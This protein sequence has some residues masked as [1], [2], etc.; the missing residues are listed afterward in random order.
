[1]SSPS[2]FIGQQL[3]DRDLIESIVSSF[4]IADYGFIQNVNA[5]KTVDVVHA[6]RLKNLEGKDL[7][8]TITRNV[9]VLTIAG[10]AFSVSVDYQ[11]GDKVLL[12]GLKN[13]IKSVD[14]A[15][16]S[17]EMTV[18]MHYTRG[19]IKALPLC[20]FNNDAKVKA[21]IKDGNFSLA[22]TKFAVT[23]SNG[24]AALEVTP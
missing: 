11:P 21:E 23:D 3:T 10:S 15:D 2:I 7:G 4:Y 1:M 9:E 8:E 22:C 17:T 14:D 24:T 5:D 19:T 6:K 20:V 12:L 18:Y 13:Y 16:K